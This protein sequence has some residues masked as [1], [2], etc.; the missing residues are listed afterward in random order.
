MNNDLCDI[1]IIHRE[2]VDLVAKQLEGS[3]SSVDLAGFLKALADP[4]RLRIIQS[5]GFAE[6]CVCDLS[7]VVGISVSGLSHQLRYLRNKKIVKFRKEGKMAY[8]SLLDEHIGQIIDIISQ[9][10][11]EP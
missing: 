4:T 3:P 2:A 1:S 6:L 8:Y 5:L 9:H 10:I 11:N 7:A